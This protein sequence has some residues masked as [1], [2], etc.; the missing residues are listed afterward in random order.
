MVP[1]AA[2]D[3]LIALF[4]RYNTAIWPAQVVAY[5]LGLAAVALVSAFAISPAPAQGQ[6]I[7]RAIGNWATN[8]SEDA[9]S[10][11][12]PK[13]LATIRGPQ[14]AQGARH[15]ETQR[16]DLTRNWGG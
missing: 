4:E 10:Q 11:M 13:G 6:P 12:N 8:G 3:G 15:I 2:S 5:L 7:G 16:K 9:A 14:P 1:I